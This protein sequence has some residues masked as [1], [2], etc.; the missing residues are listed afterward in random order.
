MLWRCRKVEEFWTELGAKLHHSGDQTKSL[1]K[2]LASEY[3]KVK[4]SLDVSEVDT[5]GEPVLR[6]SGELF[7]AFEQ[8]YQLY[9]PQG[10]ALSYTVA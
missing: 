6:N 1:F 8:Y 9:F 5:D 3:Q 7:A 4:Q 2:N 10:T